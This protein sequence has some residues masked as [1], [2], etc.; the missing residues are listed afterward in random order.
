MLIRSTFGPSARTALEGLATKTLNLEMLIERRARAQERRLVPETIAR[1][2]QEA[3]PYVPITRNLSPPS[4][5]RLSRRGRPRSYDAMRANQIG[6]VTIGGPLSRLSTDR[7]V[8]DQH[9]LEWVTPGH[10]LFEALRRH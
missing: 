10:P 6:G 3:A 2:L 5:T 8:A 4:S 7:E 1:F 9:Q